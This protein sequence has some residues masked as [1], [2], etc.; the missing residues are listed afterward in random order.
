MVEDW[1][2]GRGAGWAGGGW[3]S[4]LERCVLVCGVGGGMGVGGGR[5][6]GAG[7]EGG[8]EGGG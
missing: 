8:R 3:Y 5:E 4:I 1:Y 7:K 6:V 2:K